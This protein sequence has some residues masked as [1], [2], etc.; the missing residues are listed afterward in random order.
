MKGAEYSSKV[1]DYIKASLLIAP[2]DGVDL[3]DLSATK[4]GFT[5]KENFKDFEY[6]KENLLELMNKHNLQKEYKA[7]TKGKFNDHVAQDPA[8]NFF[9]D[10]GWI[11][12]ANPEAAH[13]QKAYLERD[14]FLM[15]KRR[16]QKIV[17][18]IQLEEQ[19]GM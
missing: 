5:T 19:Y 6:K 7:T 15:E 12:S 14:A 1:R 18:C 4:T 11:H 13:A 3:T 9:R 2:N 10:I 8:T 17:Q 16:F